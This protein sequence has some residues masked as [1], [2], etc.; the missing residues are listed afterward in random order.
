LASSAGF[1]DGPHDAVPFPIFGT[2]GTD[3]FNHHEMYELDHGLGSP[4]RVEV[5][6]GGHMRLPVELATDGVEWMEIQAMQS[7]G[8]TR[9]PKLI[10]AIFAKRMARAEAQKSPLEKMRELGSIAV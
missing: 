10:D 8:R 7:G 2:A 1:P 6:N 4:H 5:F 9:D 3:D